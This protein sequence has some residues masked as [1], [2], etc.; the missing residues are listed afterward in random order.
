[1][2]AGAHVGMGA[3]GDDAAS[4]TVCVETGARADAGRLL[5]GA[6]SMSDGGEGLVGV[7]VLAGDCCLVAVLGVAVDR[8]DG[9]A[10]VLLGVG[11]GSGGAPRGLSRRISP[12][13]PGLLEMDG[14]MMS[15]RGLGAG[16]GMACAGGEVIIADS[17]IG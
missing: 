13:M 6:F 10:R 8:V 11:D 17:A 15:C 2:S 5:G 1:M 12:G 16:L 7:G 9:G 4:G 3:P 14:Y